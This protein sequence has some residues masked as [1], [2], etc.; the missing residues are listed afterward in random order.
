MATSPA[1][2][3]SRDGGHPWRACPSKFP[4][5]DPS[6][7]TPPPSPR[8]LGRAFAPSW[9]HRSSARPSTRLSRAALLGPAPPALRRRRLWR[10]RPSGV[11]TAGRLCKALF[12]AGGFQAPKGL[13][14]FRVGRTAR[15]GQSGIV[16]S[17]YTDA[18][19][20]LV[21]AVRQAEEL[22][23]PVER[24]FSRKRSFHNKLK[25][26]ARLHE[27]ATLLS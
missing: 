25:K 17:L 9:F 10:G 7:R 12:G 21:R 23:Q 2:L 8:H 5:S 20:D 4:S 19:R 26:Q 15:A 6:R 24:A 11:A 16:T 3:H 1:A 14:I 18:N 22:A 13:G 27:P